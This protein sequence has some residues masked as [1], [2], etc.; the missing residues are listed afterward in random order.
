MKVYEGSGSTA[1]LILHF[2]TR[3]PRYFTQGNSIHCWGG[4]VGL[5]AGLDASK[6][7]KNLSLPGIKLQFLGSS[8]PTLSLYWCLHQKLVEECKA[9]VTTHTIYKIIIKVVTK[10]FQNNVSQQKHTS[11][12]HNTK[13][14]E[15]VIH[16]KS[17]HI[18]YLFAKLWSVLYT[19]PC[20]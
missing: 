3:C 7:R 15:S 10:G 18:I 11:W 16:I 4:Q 8:A 5:K 6:K 19:N 20:P 12:S 13:A 9:D 17:F 1:P 14:N 2:C